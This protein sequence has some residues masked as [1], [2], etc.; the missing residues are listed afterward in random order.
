MSQDSVTETF[1]KHARLATTPE[2][3]DKEIH[4]S[5]GLFCFDNLDEIDEDNIDRMVTEAEAEDAEM[6]EAAPQGREEQEIW[7]TQRARAQS[8]RVTRR[9]ALTR[10]ARS[11]EKIRACRCVQVKKT[12]RRLEFGDEIADRSRSPSRSAPP[13][14]DRPVMTI[15]TSP[16][17]TT[18]MAWQC[19]ASS[20]RCP[21]STRKWTLS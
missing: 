12:A 3:V 19:R 20:H 18:R 9:M 10:E 5:P 16:S 13:P 11:R 8:E 7:R 14:R 17:L 15:S 1:A 21:S 6:D 2:D 4:N